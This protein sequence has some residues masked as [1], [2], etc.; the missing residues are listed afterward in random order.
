MRQPMTRRRFLSNMALTGTG[1][2]ILSNSGSVRGTPANSKLNIAGIG[3][4]GRGAADI[5]GV[6]D[7]NLVALCDVDWKHCAATLEKFP[8]AKRY[9][10]FRKMLDEVEDKIDAVVV[11][12]PDHTHA[13]PSV[14]AMKMGKHC[15]CEKPLTHNVYEAR[16]MMARPRQEEQGRHPDGHAD[17]RRQ[18]TIVERLSWFKVGARSA[19]VA[20]GARLAGRQ[21]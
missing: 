19:P 17:S 21:L 4:G 1:L 13:P 10:D 2:V 8:N 14:M 20:R 7:Q 15:Y 16:Q 6:A 12:T 9:H 5:N 11:G 18:R 3:V